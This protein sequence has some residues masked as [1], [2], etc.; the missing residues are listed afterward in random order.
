MDLGLRGRR[1]VVTG[2]SQGIG[3]AVA[4]GL[5]AE[6]CDLVIAALAD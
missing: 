2:A 6:G 3:A 4:R 1:A 5:A